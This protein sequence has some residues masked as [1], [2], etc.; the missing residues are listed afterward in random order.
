[1]ANYGID[2][3]CVYD[4]DPTCREVSGNLVLGQACARRLIT[5]R[6][7]LIDDPNYGY[8]LRQL[9]NDDL[10]QRDIANLST[11]IT[12]ELLKD[13]RVLA[14]DVKI[15]VTSAG[16]AIVIVQITGADG[17]FQLVLSVND[18]TVDLLQPK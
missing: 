8:D 14:A 5:P 9:I 3:S 4:V 11:N 10:S 12:Q 7:T 2:I 17:P 6:G 15:T 1:M 18:V 13:E 16:N